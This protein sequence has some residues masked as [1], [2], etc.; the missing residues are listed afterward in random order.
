MRR[1]T[2]NTL[3][4]VVLVLAALPFAAKGLMY[5]RVK[6][7]VD[8][9]IAE[10]ADKAEIHY[11][12]I[13][14]ELRGAASVLGLSIR[15]LEFKQPVTVERVRVRADGPWTLLFGWSDGRPP[16]ERLGMT[17]SSVRIP[18]DDAVLGYMNRALQGHAGQPPAGDPCASPRVDVRLLKAIGYQSVALDMDMHYRF[19][20]PAEELNL[21]LDF[22]MP[23]IES[24][25]LSLRLTGLVPE[26]IQEKRIAGVRFARADLDVNVAPEY[27][28][29]YVQHCAQRLGTSPEAFL[30]AQI[31]GAR[32]QQESMGITLSPELRAALERF[33]R[34]W[35][36]IRLHVQPA[37]PLGL[38]QLAAIRPDQF[39][40]ALGISLAVNGKYVND[41]DVQ[42]DMQ[43]LM[44]LTGRQAQAAATGPQA[45]APKRVRVVRRFRLVP[46][47]TLGDHLGKWVRIHP[48]NA[49][50]REGVLEAVSNGE[51]QVRQRAHGG[52]LTSYIPLRDIAALEVQRVER[53]PLR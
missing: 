19:D 52:S 11:Q 16:P 44:A 35:G 6:M 50:V 24:M 33:N 49:P 15:P 17:L 27:G 2:R 51:A 12:G 28:K 26:D 38:G 43:K 9:S 22:D 8:K 40:Q 34:E 53:K 46:V 29:R 5:F 37:E 10:L 20:V 48:R 30:E 3:I 31:Q 42:L 18:L 7:A 39:V 14:T 45:G 25:A 13:D 1:K 4:L 21:A 41:L 32:A 36:D 47:E 23:G